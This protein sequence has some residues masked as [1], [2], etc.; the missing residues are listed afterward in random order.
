MT[1]GCFNRSG[2]FSALFGPTY[3]LRR[4]DRVCA[5]PGLM[6]GN[7]GARVAKAGG[8]PDKLREI[9]AQLHERSKKEGKEE[10][11]DKGEG[12]QDA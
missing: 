5:Q 12:D 6:R 1:V 9:L 8:I 7:R 10:Q 4:A 3:R 11:T 2:L